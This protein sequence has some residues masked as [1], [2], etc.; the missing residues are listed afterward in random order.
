MCLLGDN[1]FELT[2][3][4]C[5]YDTWHLPTTID[6]QADTPPILD[7]IMSYNTTERGTLKGKV[8][9]NLTTLNRRIAEADEQEVKNQV[10]I[11]KQSFKTFENIFGLCFGSS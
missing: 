11:C 7:A 10:E 2:P 4:A 5:A 8:T 9:R 3:D 6:N 1:S